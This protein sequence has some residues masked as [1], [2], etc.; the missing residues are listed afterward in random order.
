MAWQMNPK[1]KEFHW[2]TPQI[3]FALHVMLYAPNTDFFQHSSFVSYCEACKLHISWLFFYTSA[4]WEGYICFHI[5][6]FTYFFCAC[7]SQI[8]GE[9]IWYGRWAPL[10]HGEE[11]HW[12]SPKIILTVHILLY[13]SKCFF[14]IIHFVGI[15]SHI[16][17]TFP[18]HISINAYI[19]LHFD[20]FTYFCLGMLG[21]DSGWSNV[22]WQMN[23][24]IFDWEL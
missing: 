3:F 16:T 8:V 7:F 21:I 6:I 9:V 20:I 1:R 24:L 23:P 10:P 22:A 5:N 18:S 13:S 12:N 17:F 14:N 15:V 19:Y 4:T 2:N 11:F